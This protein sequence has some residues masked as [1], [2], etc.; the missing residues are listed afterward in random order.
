MLILSDALR[1]QVIAHARAAYPEEACGILAGPAGSDTPTRYLPMDNAAPSATREYAYRFDPA[2]QL[3]AYREMDQCGEDP[4]ALVHS[5]PHTSATP[6]AV[7]VA[8]AAE[9]G[10]HYLILSL[11]DPAAPVLR[12]WRIRDGRA[13]EETLHHCWHDGRHDATDT[14]GWRYVSE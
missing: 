9:P 8:R 6:S 7:D 5:H 13:V 14:A 2:Q 3:A 12:A 11:E 10:A 1:G 4:L